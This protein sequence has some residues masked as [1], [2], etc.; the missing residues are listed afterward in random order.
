MSP[1]V[2]AWVACTALVLSVVACAGMLFMWFSEP[3]RPGTT[4]KGFGR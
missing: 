2:V 1:T 4:H 3:I